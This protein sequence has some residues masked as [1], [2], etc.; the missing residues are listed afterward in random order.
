MRQTVKI[1]FFHVIKYFRIYWY[2]LVL[3]MLTWYNLCHWD[4]V[5]NFTFFKK[6]NGANLL[7]IVWVILIAL[8]CIGKFKG[9]GL[10]FEVP[11]VKDKE[12]VQ[13]INADYGAAIE[14]TEEGESR[15]K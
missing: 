12:D 7:F 4:A 15:E 10:E 8:L 3:L 5:T 9:F 13:R 14:K 6:F 2:A 1:V 11:S